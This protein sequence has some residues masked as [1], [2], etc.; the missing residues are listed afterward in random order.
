MRCC[1]HGGS[2]VRSRRELGLNKQARTILIWMCVLICV[3]QLGFGAIV[4]VVA[5]YAE[6]FG[7]SQT[8]IGL[9]IAIYGLARFLINVPAGQLAD[10]A[11]RRVTLATGGVV[12]VIGAI[13]CAVAP[14]YALF[15]IAR[16]IAGAGA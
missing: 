13:L 1:P 10:V 14:S 6:D 3:N 15:L 4:P 5:L 2:H 9:T 16:F 7:V 12:T 11:G 8:A